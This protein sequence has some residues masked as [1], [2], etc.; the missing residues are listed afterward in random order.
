MPGPIFERFRASGFTVPS[1]PLGPIVQANADSF[2][3][4][5]PNTTS[6]VVART[7]L[8][9]GACVENFTRYNIVLMPIYRARRVR[10]RSATRPTR[11]KRVMRRL[12]EPPQ[13]HREGVADGAATRGRNG[14]LKGTP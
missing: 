14:S 8:W 10:N 4:S 7:L 1:H 13:A 9:Q 6:T 11:R 12:S 5:S 3:E 2:A